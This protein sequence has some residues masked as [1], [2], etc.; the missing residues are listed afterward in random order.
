MSVLHT[1]IVIRAINIL[2]VVVVTEHLKTHNK[3]CIVHLSWRGVF[4]DRVLFVEIL[5]KYPRLSNWLFFYKR[6]GFYFKTPNRVPF[7]KQTNKQPKNQTKPKQ[8]KHPNHQPPTQTKT[9]FPVGITSS[10]IQ[11]S[12]HPKSFDRVR[13][14]RFQS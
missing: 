2:V 13:L 8:S 9:E 1:V 4:F 3:N 11:K 7:K 12:I 5:I 14:F 6:K 10:Q